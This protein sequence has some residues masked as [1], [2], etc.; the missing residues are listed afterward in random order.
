MIKR[1]VVYF[2]LRIGGNLL[3]VGVVGFWD[4]LILGRGVF[5]IVLEDG[6]GRK[7]FY[8]NLMMIVFKV[9]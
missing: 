8:I 6:F 3:G 4:L 2:G 9:K 5:Y 1:E 7:L